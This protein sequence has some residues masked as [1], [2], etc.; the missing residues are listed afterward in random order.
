VHYA[1]NLII[2]IFFFHFFI[3]FRDDENGAEHNNFK[4]GALNLPLGK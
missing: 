1:D 3:S 4:T 2:Q